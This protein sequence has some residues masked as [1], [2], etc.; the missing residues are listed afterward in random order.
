M[1]KQLLSIVLFL[2][3]V[4]AHIAFAEKQTILPGGCIRKDEVHHIFILP[5]RFAI[6]AQLTVTPCDY[7]KWELVDTDHLEILQYNFTGSGMA[8]SAGTQ[9]WVLQ[10]RVPGYYKVTFKRNN[11]TKRVLIHAHQDILWCGKKEP[12]API[13]WCGTARA[14]TRHHNIITF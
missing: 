11:E 10:A 6:Q 1:N 9:E 3:T 12:N 8:G 7:E 13:T 14:N 2:S 4:L 5:H